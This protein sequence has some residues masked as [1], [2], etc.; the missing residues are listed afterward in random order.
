M[1]IDFSL[2]TISNEN[3]KYRVIT[4]TEGRLCV[5]VNSELLI[6]E[7]GVLIIEFAICLKRWLAALNYSP[8]ASMFYETMDSD[9]KPILAFDYLSRKQV[10]E[11]K[12]V[13]GNKLCNPFVSSLLLIDAAS[14]FLKNLERELK[15]H[16][17]H[18][19]KIYDYCGG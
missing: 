16:S 9:E 18:L 5:T 19:V 2:K 13:W 4:D 6:C 14:T 17:I 12:S 8:Y 1:R 3:K 10:F 15:E 7:D 11:I